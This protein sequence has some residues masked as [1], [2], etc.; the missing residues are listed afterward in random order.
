MVLPF[1]FPCRAASAA[2]PAT[3]SSTTTATAT[4]REQWD[5]ASETLVIYNRAFA[6]SEELARYYAAARK[7]PAERVIGL[8]CPIEETISRETFESTIR[9][10][11]LRVL[12]DK[13]WWVMEKRDLLDPS[14]KRYAQVPQVIRQ[15]IKVVALIRGM[16]L[17]VSR[18]PNAKEP[19][20][21]E[22][23]EASVDSEIA[24][25]GLI[26]RPMKGPLE[27]R[28][29]KSGVPFPECQEARGQLLVGRLDAADDDTVRRMIDDSIKAERTG[30]WGRAVVDFSLMDGGYEEGEQWLE[31]CVKL[32]KTNGIPMEVD[33]YR[34]VFRDS[35]PLP[36][37]VLYFGWYT[38]KITGAIASPSFR[39][40]PGA[41]ACHLHS[42]SSC[43]LRTKTDNWVGPLLEKGAAAA[44]GNVWEPYLTLTVHFDILNVRLLSGATLGEAAWAATPGISW[45]TVLVGDPL[46]RPFPKRRPIPAGN[47]R[48]QDYALYAGLVARLL[49]H[50]AKKFR[51]EL[52]RIAEERRSPHLLE[53]MGLLSA[54]EG[55]NREASDFFQ[56][57]RAWFDSPGDQLRCAL[58]ESE[59]S[60]RKGDAQASLELV[61]RLLKDNRYANIPALGA[62]AVLNKEMG[63]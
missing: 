54:V 31:N 38:S 16:P 36:D 35:W 39:F 27:N 14:G 12:L 17:R 46:Y 11:L 5:P 20:V 55:N 7:I 37:T 47:S 13:K 15:N 2:G 44:L 4:A 8:K 33:R 28:Y 56:H 1:A 10:P 22:V 43:V 51:R 53:L 25:L 61:K 34:E 50:D 63:G 32:Y 58:Y 26:Q 3:S 52:L 18:I 21:G 9:E 57:A 23:D 29:Y 19:A 45:M 30:L 48:D 6:G 60:R 59:T 62:A 24:A 41:I 40:K 49:P 42:F